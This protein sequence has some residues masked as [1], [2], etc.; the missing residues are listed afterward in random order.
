MYHPS[1]FMM[2]ML[3]MPHSFATHANLIND[4]ES[5][6][7]G[8]MYGLLRQALLHFAILPWAVK[9][10]N[11]YDTLHMSS[12]ARCRPIPIRWKRIVCRALLWSAP[13]MFK[14]AHGA[15]RLPHSLVGQDL[16]RRYR[17][18]LCRVSTRLLQCL[19]TISPS[20][21]ALGMPSN[22]TMWVSTCL[23]SSC[24]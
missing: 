6:S 22:S 2:N 21:R 23:K 1:S 10:R 15:M 5:E 11:S 7:L 4:Y 14:S 12:V 20:V 18:L 9:L 8:P 19:W 24:L 16:C 13:L 3:T 17:V